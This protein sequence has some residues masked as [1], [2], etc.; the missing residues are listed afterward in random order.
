MTNPIATALRAAARAINAQADAID[1][2]GATVTT[3]KPVLIQWGADLVT[4]EEAER[5]RLAEIADSEKPHDWVDWAPGVLPDQAGNNIDPPPI[6]E[7]AKRFWA[8]MERQVPFVYDD[9]G[10]RFNA[11]TCLKRGNDDFERNVRRLWEGPE[12]VA[13]RAAPENAEIWPL[14]R[15]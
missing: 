14:I 9:H 10:E 2:Q 8:Q 12:G 3:S 5:R 15:V 1:A 4:L 11:L 13:Y 7:G 6:Y